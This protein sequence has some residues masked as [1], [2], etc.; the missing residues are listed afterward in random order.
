MR[1]LMM[2]LV[3][4]QALVLAGL[5][6]AQ[7]SD[8]SDFK[9]PDPNDT[10]AITRLPFNKH[11]E[12]LRILKARKDWEALEQACYIYLKYHHPDSIPSPGYPTFQPE[13][14]Y[15][16]YLEAF[17][18]KAE[19]Q[20]NQGKY[21]EAAQTVRDQHA[22]RPDPKN[23]ERTLEYHRL[24]D[25]QKKI[26]DLEMQAANDRLKARQ[27]AL[28]MSQAL[29]SLLKEMQAEKSMTPEKMKEYQARFKKLHEGI[30]A[31]LT[32]AID[33]KYPPDLPPVVLSKSQNEALKKIRDAMAD[34]EKKV[35]S[36]L[37]NAEQSLLEIVKK[38]ELTWTGLESQLK[39]L[40]DLQA[41]I[42]K[43]QEAMNRILAGDLTAAA[44][45][46][47][48]AM[49]A[50]LDKLMKEHEGLFN[51]IV[52]G[53]MNADAFMKLKPEE[54]KR[55]LELLVQ[56]MGAR[57]K[58]LETNAALD[59]KIKDLEQRKT[60]DLYAM[61]NEEYVFHLYKHILG[62]NP[63][64]AGFQYWLDQLKKGV[65]REQLVTYFFF[66]KEFLSKHDLYKMSDEQYVYFLYKFI[67]KRAPDKE[68][69]KHHLTALKNGTVSREVLVQH[70]M[71]SPEYLGVKPVVKGPPE[72]A[73]GPAPVPPATTDPATGATTGTESSG[74]DS[75]PA[76]SLTDSF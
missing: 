1:W 56:V 42:S 74:S 52:D 72:P 29:D 37:K 65:K 31:Q 61:T 73:P 43:L 20:A 34:V 4:V 24:H 50:E 71:F 46:E 32:L 21:L 41:R 48:L 12:Y 54:Q 44:I 11:I 6:Y 75:A 59:R 14:K 63:E 47:L 53:F 9:F 58:I 60:Y 27:K 67:L 15:R 57:Q 5:G 3:V 8:S 2:G 7:V 69:F 33:Y 16:Y 25:A 62:R 10:E 76:S 18:L 28:E 17:A 23:V 19:A 55:F 30:K 13:E 68:G 49:K 51:K 64:Y 45:K 39:Q 38:F 22:Y 66:S 40:V 36:S 70:F 26:F 35:E